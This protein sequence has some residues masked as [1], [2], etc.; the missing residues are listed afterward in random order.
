MTAPAMPQKVLD[1]IKRSGTLVAEAEKQAAAQ[2]QRDAAVAALI[3]NVVESLVTNNR[4][5]ADLRD[6]AAE[7]LKDPVKTLE[8]LS[9]VAAHRSDAEL[10]HLGGPEKTASS[11]TG[12]DSPYVGL[13]SSEPRESDSLLMERMLGSR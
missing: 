9:S 8:I 5:P 11:R 3:P 13:P 10:G 4:I 1:Y 6:K 7:Q 2:A 12:K